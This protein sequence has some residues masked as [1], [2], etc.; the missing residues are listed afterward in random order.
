MRNAHQRGTQKPVDNP[1]LRSPVGN[2]RIRRPEARGRYPETRKLAEW[3]PVRL[4]YSATPL[5]GYGGLD[6][7]GKDPRPLAPYRGL[8]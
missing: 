1:K 4:G 3:M 2:P 7:A 8:C 5:A 6:V